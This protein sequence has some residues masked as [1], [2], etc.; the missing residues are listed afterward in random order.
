MKHCIILRWRWYVMSSFPMKTIDFLPDNLCCRWIYF[1]SRYSHIFFLLGETGHISWDMRHISLILKKHFTASSTDFRK[2]PISLQ[3]LLSLRWDFIWNAI[4]IILVKWL[5]WLI[6]SFLLYLILDNL[7]NFQ[8][9]PMCFFEREL[10]NYLFSKYSVGIVAR[11]LICSC[12]IL[13]LILSAT[14]SCLEEK[15]KS[16]DCCI[17]NVFVY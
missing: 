5:Y 4:F 2:K 6:V 11:F 17:L 1:I 12:S 3:L 9:N 14:N 8:W 7:E 10:A 13:S 16:K 15:E